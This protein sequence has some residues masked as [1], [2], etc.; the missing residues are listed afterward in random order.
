MMVKPPQ[1][2][3]SRLTLASLGSLIV[4]QGLYGWY[5]VK[6]G[7]EVSDDKIPRVSHFRLAAHYTLATTFFLSCIWQG[8]N[9]MLSNKR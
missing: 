1:R 9:H 6:S 4:F 3:C 8:C 5:M 7:L 2:L